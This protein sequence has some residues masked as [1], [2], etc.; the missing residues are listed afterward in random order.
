M[1]GNLVF[2]GLND[3]VNSASI[4]G[5]LQYLFFIPVNNVVTF[6]AYNNTT[7]YVSQPSP[8]FLQRWYTALMQPTNRG[9]REEQARGDGGTYFDVQVNG[10]IPFDRAG[11]QLSLEYMTHERFIVMAQLGNSV[12]KV[13]GNKKNPCRFFHSQ[14]TGL[15]IKGVPGTNISFSWQTDAKPPILSPTDLASLFKQLAPI[16]S[17]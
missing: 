7:G 15:S 12:V 6:P 14:D 2:N 13:L 16:Q 9:Y 3:L 10:F 11:N 1:T 5:G 8:A 17:V 4:G